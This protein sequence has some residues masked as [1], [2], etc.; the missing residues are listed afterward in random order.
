MANSLT[1]RKPAE[2]ILPSGEVVPC[3]YIEHG[4]QVTL[5]F[6]QYQDDTKQMVNQFYRSLHAPKVRKSSKNKQ[7]LFPSHKQKYRKD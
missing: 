6:S 5:T 7:S 2:L 1:T 3:S 4:A